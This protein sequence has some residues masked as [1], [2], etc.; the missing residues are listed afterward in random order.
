MTTP[1]DAGFWEEKYRLGEAGWDK[2]E[3]APPIRRMLRSLP[4]PKGARLAV[5]GAGL[6]HEAFEAASLGFSVTAIDFAP[7]AIRGMEKRARETGL[8]IE[9]WERDLFS[10]QEASAGRFD[11][12][13]E[14]TCFCAIEPSRRRE[15]AQGVRALLVP[16]GKLF[17]LFYAHGRPGG[18]PFDVQEPEL[19]ELFSSDFVIETLRW[20]P[21]SFSARM[22]QELEGVFV[23]RP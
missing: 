1:S 17:G 3:C 23:R 9:L 13:L 22:Q 4:W 21:D 11:A 12:V 7:S 19:R 10:L 20:A 8:P 14:H 2:G 16:G 18:P 5:V 15:Y 6:G